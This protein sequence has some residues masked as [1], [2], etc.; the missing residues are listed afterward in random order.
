MINEKG[1][2][3][4]QVVQEWTEFYYSKLL[5]SRKVG[6]V[7]QLFKCVLQWKERDTSLFNGVESTFLAGGGLE[8]DR[9]SLGDPEGTPFPVGR[10]GSVAPTQC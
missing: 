3:Y 4:A 5:C 6:S 7:C 1:C 10:V 2:V 9:T 8:A